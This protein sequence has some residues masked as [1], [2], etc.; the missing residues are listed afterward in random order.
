MGVA[1]SDKFDEDQYGV[2][3]ANQCEVCKIVTIEFL[4]LLDKSKGKH[5]VLETGYSVEK[6]KKK[7]KYAKSELRLIETRSVCHSNIAAT[8][9]SFHS[10]QEKYFKICRYF[11]PE[12]FDR[13][14]R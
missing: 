3:Y 2:K 12:L 1:N 5:E 6:Q 9:L 7:T 13:E 11:L 8:F 14:I 4:S 10:K